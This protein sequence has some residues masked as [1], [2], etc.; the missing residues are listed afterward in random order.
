MSLRT[1]PALVHE[2]FSP[3]QKIYVSFPSSALDPTA[4]YLLPGFQLCKGT[5]H[6][7]LKHIPFLLFTEVLHVTKKYL[8]VQLGGFSGM[9]PPCVI[10]TQMEGK[11][12]APPPDTPVRLL[13]TLP[14]LGHCC[15]C[16]RGEPF[17]SCSPR[18]RHHRPHALQCLASFIPRSF[19]EFHLRC[20]VLH[21][22]GEF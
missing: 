14:A 5:E 8:S 18:K 12:A 10:R 19:C 6:G 4:F 21:C 15:V 22:C 20:C 16:C 11:G 13:P 7:N 1:A 3:H 17:P 9:D 2:L